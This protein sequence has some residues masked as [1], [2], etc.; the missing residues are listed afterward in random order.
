MN[1]LK[2]QFAIDYAEVAKLDTVDVTLL[3]LKRLTM[4]ITHQKSWQQIIAK[5]KEDAFYAIA[6]TIDSDSS[7]EACVLAWIDVNKI[8]SNELGFGSNTEVI[9]QV[10]I[11]NIFAGSI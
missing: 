11:D 5:A 3:I 2:A 7:L 6:K 9:K 10:K 1:W 8:I 4:L